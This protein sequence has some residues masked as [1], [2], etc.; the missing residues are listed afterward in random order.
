MLK[1]TGHLKS[2][3]FKCPVCLQPEW[4]SEKLTA[5]FMK[6]GKSYTAGVPVHFMLFTIL[7]VITFVLDVSTGVNIT[8]VVAPWLIRKVGALPLR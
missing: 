4:Q 8:D 7:I 1:L 2:S 5:I 3:D 6:L